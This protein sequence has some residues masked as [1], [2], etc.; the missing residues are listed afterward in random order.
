MS[1]IDQNIQRN[2]ARL[3]EMGH[4]IRANTDAVLAVLDKLN[5]APG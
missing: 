5:D 2:N 1:D 4:W 3:D